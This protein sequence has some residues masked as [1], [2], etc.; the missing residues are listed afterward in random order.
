MKGKTAIILT[1]DHGN[2]D[3]PPTGADRYQVPFFVWGPGATAGADLYALN[4]GLNGAATRHVAANYP[5]TTY[6]GL[7]PI[8]NAEA[9][10]LALDLLGLGAIPGSTFDAAQTLVVPE[11]ATMSLLAL[12]ALALL[13][14]R[15]R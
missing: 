10:N 2:Q 1:A 4:N 14:R 5:M 15:T 7:Q 11:P 12:G 3:N 6:A 8:R 9:S 13:R